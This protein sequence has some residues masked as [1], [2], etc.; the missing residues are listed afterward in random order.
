MSDDLAAQMAKE[1]KL[2]SD[3]VAG[4]LTAYLNSRKVKAKADE[5][6][7]TSGRWPYP[8]TD[9]LRELLTDEMNAEWGRIKRK[10][11]YFEEKDALTLQLK[12]GKTPAVT[13]DLKY[14]GDWCGGK[15]VILKKGDDI[16]KLAKKEYGY[17]AYAAAIWEANDAVLGNS[18]KVLPAG[19]GLE[20]PQIWVPRWVKAPKVRI[21]M[22]AAAEE[23]QKIPNLETDWNTKSSRTWVQDLGVVILEVDFTI[24]GELKIANKGTVD[25][26]FDPKAQTVAIGKALG[27]L[28]TGYTADFKSRSDSTS[29]TLA[30][31]NK[32]VAGLKF[33]GKLALASGGVSVNLGVANVV[34]SEGD[35]T[36]T[37]S[38][39]AKAD[40]RLYP[41]PRPV[42]SD[43]Y[44][45]SVA[46]NLAVV[47]AVVIVVWPVGV[48]VVQSGAVRQVGKAVAEKLVEYG[49]KFPEALAH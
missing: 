44:E 28:T 49:P 17:E 31:F 16:A 18:C 2:Y 4:L 35:L 25:V 42:E 45:A 34:I 38:F 27:P 13:A 41:K 37:G 3:E 21:P 19:F 15:S 6:N 30:L 14:R 48:R 36:V 8:P 26:T 12:K 47:A 23:F 9:E 20:L 22:V 5:L 39:K 1:E 10:Y 29:A 24:T 32:D 33:S 7:S 43:A 40:L 11:E 46:A